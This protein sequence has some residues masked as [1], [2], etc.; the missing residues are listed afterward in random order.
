MYL[1]KQSKEQYI[2]YIFYKLTLL[3]SFHQSDTDLSLT[4]FTLDDHTVMQTDS[5]YKIQELYLK[6]KGTHYLCLSTPNAFL[7]S[8]LLIYITE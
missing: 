5:A 1:D 6:T 4:V 8:T 7:S 2:I 3:C